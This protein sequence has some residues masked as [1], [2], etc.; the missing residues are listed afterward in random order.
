[1]VTTKA[2]LFFIRQL[3]YRWSGPMIIIVNGKLDEEKYVVNYIRKHYLPPRLTIC[4]YFLSYRHPQAKVFPV[5]YLRNLAIRNVETTHYLIMDMDLWPTV[6]TYDEIIHLPE[7]VLSNT[8]SAVILPIFFFNKPR[9]LSRCVGFKQCA[10]FGLN[11]MPENKTELEACI[12]E[13]LCEAR[14]PN[15]RT[16]VS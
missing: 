4:L 5:N 13:R 3:L 6:N 9:V 12:L 2:R 15:I 11:L 8:R 16:H 1:M 10:L 7:T 14:K